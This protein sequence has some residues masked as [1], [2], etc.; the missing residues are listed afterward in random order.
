MNFLCSFLH[1]SN[2]GLFVGPSAAL[3]VVGAVKAARQ[4]GPGHTVVTVICDGGDRY[5]SK[6]YSPQWLSAQGL[7]VGDID[8]PEAKA[9][10]AFVK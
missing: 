8:S 2:E 7:A 6:L 10:A 3:N 1:C 4:L 5:R 9:K